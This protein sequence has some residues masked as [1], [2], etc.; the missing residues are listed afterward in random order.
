M[1]ELKILTYLHEN[2]FPT[3]LT[4][5]FAGSGGQQAMRNLKDPINIPGRGGHQK[6][7]YAIFS[8][9]RNFGPKTSVK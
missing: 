4:F 9:K 7:S 1:D 6:K 5:R 8:K 2:Y 3:D